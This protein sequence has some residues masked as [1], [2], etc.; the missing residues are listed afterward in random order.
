MTGHH[1]LAQ[2]IKFTIG[3]NTLNITKCDKYSYSIYIMLYELNCHPVLTMLTKLTDYKISH[4]NGAIYNHQWI[5][6]TIK[7]V[8]SIIINGLL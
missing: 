5:T 1:T 6:I 2:L 4:Q 3:D 7:M 8:P